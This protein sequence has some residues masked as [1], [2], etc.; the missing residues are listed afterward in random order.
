MSSVSIRE[1]MN[2][3][4]PMLKPDRELILGVRC[5]V[6]PVYSIMH[7]HFQIG[8]YLIP[9]DPDIFIRD[10]ELTCPSPYIAV[11]TFVQFPNELF[12]QYLATEPALPGPFDGFF[13]IQLLLFVKFSLRGN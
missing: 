2:T 7:Q 10:P 5:I 13:N 6:D 12:G 4:D 8:G 11:H 1:T 3:H 9:A